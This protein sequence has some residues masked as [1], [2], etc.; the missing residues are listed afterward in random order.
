MEVMCTTF[1]LWLLRGRWTFSNSFPFHQLNTE[2][3]EDDGALE[4]SVATNWKE[5]GSLNQYVMK[6][7]LGHLGGSVG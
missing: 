7:F 4:D 1:K 3:A 2:T 6:S 5:T